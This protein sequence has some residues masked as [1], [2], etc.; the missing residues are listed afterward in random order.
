M[1][2]DTPGEPPVLLDVIV[3]A[4]RAEGL[5]RACLS[6]LGRY[7][8]E[9]G[10]MRVQVV[11]NASGDSTPDMVA[12]EFPEVDLTRLSHNAGFSAANN[13]GIRRSTA[14]FVLIL[15]PDT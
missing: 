9:L 5:L 15:N 2:H 10:P 3:V 14:P 1:S 8:P 4:F 12:R 7:G 13:I 6:S 11:D